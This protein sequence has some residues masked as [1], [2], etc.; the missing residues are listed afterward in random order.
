MWAE[1][2][3]LHDRPARSRIETQAARNTLPYLTGSVHNFAL[4][5]ASDLSFTHSDRTVDDHVPHAA[6]IGAVNG[7]AHHV[8]N[9][10]PL[11]PAHVVLNQIGVSADL[12][13]ADGVVPE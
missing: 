8:M 5:G 13:R 10:R 1:L 7:I 3:C 4:V 11:R 2:L 6:A 12:N 9:W